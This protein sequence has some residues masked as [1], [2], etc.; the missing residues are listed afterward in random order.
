LLCGLAL[1]T[2]GLLAVPVA[3][4]PA[5]LAVALSALAI[6]LGLTQ[7]SLT[8]LISRRAGPEEQGEV[9]GVS[10][11]VG[12][13]SRVLGPASAGLFFGE[14]GR[15]AAFFWGAALVIAALWVAIRL[16]QSLG[17]AD[18]AGAEQQ[19]RSR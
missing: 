10:Q 15:D 16:I 11:S 4:I 6:G 19:G 2:V 13:L 7:P 18:L 8:S 14:F 5:V 9:L 1:I 3:R 17:A 12:S